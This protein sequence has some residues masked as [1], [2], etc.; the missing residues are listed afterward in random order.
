MEQDRE[1]NKS[2]KGAGSELD[3]PPLS[4]EERVDAN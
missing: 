2:D 1:H 3:S 4:E